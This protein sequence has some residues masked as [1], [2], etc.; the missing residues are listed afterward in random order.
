MA[1]L[2]TDR[3]YLGAAKDAGSAAS[4]VSGLKRRRGASEVDRAGG[5]AV[6]KCQ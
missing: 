5:A 6:T 3:R 2:H 1:P 4:S